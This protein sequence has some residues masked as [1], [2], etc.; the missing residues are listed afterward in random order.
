MAKTD[1]QYGWWNSY[2]LQCGTI[3]TLISPGDCTLQCGMLHWNHDTE[4]ATWQHPA[5]WHMALESWQSTIQVAVPAMRHVD[6][7]WHATEFA[8]TSAILEFYFWFQFRPYH[9]NQHVIWHQ[10][11]KFYP[12]R[13]TSAEKMA[14]CRFSRR[15][16]SAILDFNG[17][18]MGS[19][20]S[21]CTTYYRSSNDTIALN[22]LVFEKITFLQFG[23]R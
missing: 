17:P 2:T 13:I 16:I 1:F 9:R 23:D 21:P 15:R 10:S 3:V 8:Q 6:L 12:N 20:K 4:F 7:G 18:I 19:L 11:A 5:M 14:S 22:C